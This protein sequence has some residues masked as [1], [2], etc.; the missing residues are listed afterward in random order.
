MYPASAAAAFVLSLL[1]T[2]AP[3]VQAACG[4]AVGYADAPQTVVIT[5]RWVPAQWV[6]SPCGSLVYQDGYWLTERT[7]ESIAPRVIY[8]EP[9][10]YEQLPRYAPA[11]VIVTRP[12]CAPDWQRNGSVIITQPAPCPPPRCGRPGFE[13]SVSLSPSRHCR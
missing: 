1:F 3:T 13:L 11:P 6:H 7:V 4:G 5:Q 2:C 12:A 10:R 9:A 8:V